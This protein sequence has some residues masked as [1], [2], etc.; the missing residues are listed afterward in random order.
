MI[1]RNKSCV[2]HLR[3]KAAFALDVENLFS[4]WINVLNFKNP[5]EIYNQA[6]WKGNLNWTKTRFSQVSERFKLRFGMSTLTCGKSCSNFNKVS[7]KTSTF[8]YAFSLRLI[9]IR[10]F[11]F[12]REK[13]ANL[14]FLTT[15]QGIFT[16]SSNLLKMLSQ[17]QLRSVFA[18]FCSGVV[19]GSGHLIRQSFQYANINEIR[20]SLRS[21]YMLLL[22]WLPFGSKCNWCSF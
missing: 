21:L 9:N 6:T 3:F 5:F 19:F 7:H 14:T 13:K 17:F 11:L 16:K 8:F 15:M 2:S 22:E 4:K 1:W 18:L 10:V 12:F 20:F